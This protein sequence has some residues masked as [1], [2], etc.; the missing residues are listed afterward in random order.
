MKLGWIGLGAMGRPMAAHLARDFETL[1]WNRTSGTATRHAEQHGTRAVDLADLAGVDV[2]FLCLPTTAV[3]R[4]VL[5]GV[6]ADL[7]PGLLVVDCTSGDPEESRVLAE[8]LDRRG[9]GY[10]D[11]P[12]SGQTHG[13]E[14]GVLTVMVGGDGAALER[15]LPALET[16]A[17]RV[18]HVGPVGAGHAM[19]AANNFL[20]ALNLWGAAEALELLEHEGVGAEVAVAVLQ[21][22]SGRSQVTER[23]IPDWVLHPKGEDTFRLGQL[24]KDVGVAARAARRAGLPAPLHARTDELYAHLA[25]AL[26]FAAETPVSF[27]AMRGRPLDGPGPERGDR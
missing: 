17:K 4:E 8:R 1:V 13:A 10:L 16:F 25:E 11:A 18:I 5:G 21:S 20:F 12:V 7:E 3:V 22:S 19:K 6:E 2:L 14:Q 23:F 9:V 15:A 26:G 27:E 24:A